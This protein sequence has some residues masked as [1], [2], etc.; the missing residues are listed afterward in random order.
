MQ[1]GTRKLKRKKDGFVGGGKE[2]E[3]LPEK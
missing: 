1:I 2:R 3:S